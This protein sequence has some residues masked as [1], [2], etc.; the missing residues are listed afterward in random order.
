[1][2]KVQAEGKNTFVLNRLCFTLSLVILIFGFHSPLNGAD[3]ERPPIDINLIIDGSS[4]FSG[5]RDEIIPWVFERLD[6][7]MVN[8]D[9][10]TVWNTEKIAKVIYSGIVNNL[11]EKETVKRSISE[12]S[13]SG[14]YADFS[15]A[16]SEASRK[17]SSSF[18]YTLLVST[19][20]EALTSVLTS[21]QAG[22]LRYS[23]V[24]EFPSWRVLVVGLNLET[25]VRRSAAAFFGS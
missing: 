11:A 9:R 4:A 5:A 6:Q 12:L 22:L 18:S 24:E 7:I 25:K 16:L 2:E 1:M 20:N 14:D 13:A 10:V 17:Q 15:G 23:R 3:A 8:G 19:S 21:P